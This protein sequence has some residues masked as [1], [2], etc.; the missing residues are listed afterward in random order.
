MASRRCGRE[1]QADLPGVSGAAAPR[2][3]IGDGDLRGGAAGI[4]AA[5][6]L[7]TRAKMPSFQI[8]RPEFFDC[9]FSISFVPVNSRKT[10]AKSVKGVARRQT[11]RF[12]GPVYGPDCRI[13][14]RWI[15]MRHRRRGKQVPR[16][17]DKFLFVCILSHAVGIV[18]AGRG[19]V[20][21]LFHLLSIRRRI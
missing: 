14:I 19:I 8:L 9:S 21:I 5:G 6:S 1:T 18:N 11:R 10:Q 2:R 4:F 7:S 13:T 12:V 20:H 17:I 3:L 16:H 15:G